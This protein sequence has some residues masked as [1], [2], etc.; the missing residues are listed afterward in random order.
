LARGRAAPG[1]IDLAADAPVALIW[2]RPLPRQV[3]SCRA[4]ANEKAARALGR[5]LSP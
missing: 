2:R 1:V 3:R 5:A 4:G